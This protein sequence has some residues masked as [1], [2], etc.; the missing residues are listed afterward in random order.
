ML[1]GYKINFPNNYLL[2]QTE[3][4]FMKNMIYTQYSK[5]YGSTQKRCLEYSLQQ[6]NQIS[7]PLKLPPTL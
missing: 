3:F 5:F 4:S 7:I 1:K 6:N 2:K